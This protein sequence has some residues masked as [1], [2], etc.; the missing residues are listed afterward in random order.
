MCPLDN[1]MNKR[2]NIML[3]LAS[4]YRTTNNIHIS[5]DASWASNNATYEIIIGSVQVFL[6]SFNGKK[7]KWNECGGGVL[8]MEE[9]KDW[10]TEMQSAEREITSGIRLQLCRRTP[11]RRGACGS[12]LPSAGLSPGSGRTLTVPTWA[13]LADGSSANCASCVLWLKW[14]PP[15][16]DGIDRTDEP[17]RIWLISS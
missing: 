11:W 8:T 12:A 9:N 10:D 5:I 16:C 7:Y 3:P 17:K 15:Y 13:D 6:L 2:C 4:C 1:E 14:K